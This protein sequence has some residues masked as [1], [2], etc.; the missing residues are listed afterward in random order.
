MADVNIQVRAS[1][2]AR[3]RQVFRGTVSEA[4][5]AD[6]AITDSNR[7]AQRAI[8]NESTRTSR[9]RTTDARRATQQTVRGFR[10]ESQAAARLERERAR[11]SRARERE[12]RRAPGG[13]GRLPFGGGVGTAVTGFAAGG[14]AAATGAVLGAINQTL[15]NLTAA[16]QQIAGAQGF[17]GVGQRAVTAQ[18]FGVE[19]TRLTSEVGAVR[20][21]DLEQQAE[22]ARD[23]QEQILGVAQATNQEPGALLEA[24]RTIQT[25]FG[26]FDFGRENLQALAEEA[27]RSGDDLNDLARFAGQFQRQFGQQDVGQLFDITA[28]AGLTSSLTTGAFAANFAGVSGVFR[29]AVDPR[30]QQSSEQLLRDF[31]AISNAVRTGTG[32]AATASTQTR[33]LLFALS[34]PGTLR[35]IER[36]TGRRG[37]RRVRLGDYR[38]E[39]GRL[40]LS[41]FFSALSQNRNFRSLEDI[42]QA[43]PNI[44]AAAGLNTILQREREGSASSFS[45]LQSVSQ[46]AGSRLRSQELNRVSNTEQQ[47]Q[48]A[49]GIGTQVQGIRGV[50][51]VSGRSRIASATQARLQAEG[52]GG[53]TIAGFENTINAL[54]AA[55]QSSPALRSLVERVGG[56]QA[57]Q[58]GFLGTIAE[59]ETAARGGSRGILPALA[60]ALREDREA[61]ARGQ[62]KTAGP[63]G[64]T[65]A[66]DNTQIDRLQGA[67]RQGAA[68]GVRDALEGSDR[69]SG[70]PAARGS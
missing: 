35:R 31:V 29:S 45:R 16:T 52:L 30:G 53:E 1:G 5:R 9:Q 67:I 24:M 32:D 17:Q 34:D 6:R 41:G 39:E 69:T 36:A 65:A 63:K 58:G 33:G 59:A 50:E 27:Q 51:E 68:Q 62:T 19:L 61:T 7:R 3:L 2:G 20:G 21:L 60:Q 57:P 12:R 44:R 11:S 22:L 46:A 56:A 40:D 37:G 25:E 55:T 54:A 18:N 70:G 23:L 43:V 14:I 38:D 64:G 8:R 42:S 15:Q 10:A 28:Q 13:L 4:R 66:F 48:L 47:R 49:V 26:E